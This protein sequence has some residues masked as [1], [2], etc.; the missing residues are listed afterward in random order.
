MRHHSPP[1]PP[2]LLSSSPPYIIIVTPTASPLPHHHRATKRVR[3][4]LKQP[5]GTTGAC[6][7]SFAPAE[8]RILQKLQENDQNRANTDT[9]TEE[10]TKSR[11]F[12]Q[13]GQEVNSRSN[14]QPLVNK[15]TL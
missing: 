4:A 9:G 2:P 12:L 3:V 14:G 6:G 11:E 1:Q 10:H 8:V 13:K 7:L 15:S 5:I